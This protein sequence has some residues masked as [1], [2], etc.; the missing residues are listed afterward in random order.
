MTRR[1]I[2]DKPLTEAEKTRRKKEKRKRMGLVRHEVWIRPEWKA[3]VN[4]LIENLTGELNSTG[5]ENE[6]C[7]TE[8][9]GSTNQ[10][11]SN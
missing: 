9:M 6:K 5:L 7:S 8:Q 2:G 11:S 10:K 4:E 3:K 1:L